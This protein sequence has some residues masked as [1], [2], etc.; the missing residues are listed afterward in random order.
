MK[1]A[2]TIAEKSPISIRGTKNVLRH[3]RDHSVEDGLEYIAE[4]NSNMLFSDDMAEV[5]EAMK[6]KRKPDFKD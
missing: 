6:E 2:A 4:W 5:F 3:S 1:I